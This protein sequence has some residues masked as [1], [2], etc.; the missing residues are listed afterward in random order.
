MPARPQAEHRAPVR[1][2]IDSIRPLRLTFP[3]TDLNPPI[4]VQ[5]SSHNSAVDRSYKSATNWLHFANIQL[6]LNNGGYLIGQMDESNGLWTAREL[7]YYLRLRNPD[8]ISKMIRA[9]RITKADGHVKIG[10]LNRFIRQVVEERVKAGLFGRGL[11]AEGRALAAPE[12]KLHLLEPR[13]RTGPEA[14][15]P[16]FLSTLDSP[17]LKNL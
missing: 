1:L 4:R 16:V 13:R 11:N 5:F 14:D 7:A 8:T 9:R 12:R 17:A 3:R 2:R 10:R 6:S 15:I